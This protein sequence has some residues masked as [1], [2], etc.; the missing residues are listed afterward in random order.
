MYGKLQ[1]LGVERWIDSGPATNLRDSTN[2]TIPITT[3][4]AMHSVSIS[5]P[6]HVAGA[7]NV[8][9]E[10][11]I[12]IALACCMTIAM[13][14]VANILCEMGDISVSLFRR[15]S[16]GSRSPMASIVDR[17]KIFPHQE[18]GDP[19]KLQT[20][21][22][23]PLP[24]LVPEAV[25]SMDANS[26]DWTSTM[27]HF[28]KKHLYQL[29]KTASCSSSPGSLTTCWYYLPTAKP[30]FGT[31]WLGPHRMVATPADVCRALQSSQE[32]RQQ[33]ELDPDPPDVGNADEDEST[34]DGDH[35]IKTTFGSQ[36]SQ[37]WSSKTLSL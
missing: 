35:S 28:T 25:D 6:S 11:E 7:S 12:E 34:D 20:D 1:R 8:S 37:C 23:E 16:S 22:P 4:L 18:S 31:G 14:V 26:Q 15:T 5:V 29:S 13:I 19:S 36:L 33:H 9:R 32:S 30:S 3:R 2:Q 27:N 24:E 10:F 17:S 21:S